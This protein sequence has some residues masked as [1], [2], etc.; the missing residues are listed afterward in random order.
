MRVGALFKAIPYPY[1]PQ[2]ERRIREQR[3][4][5]DERNRRDELAGLQAMASRALAGELGPTAK[6]VA[7][8]WRKHQ[9]V[10]NLATC[11]RDNL[12]QLRTLIRRAHSGAGRYR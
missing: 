6:S 11:G 12:E 2:Q 7:E 4:A 3:A 5:E 1:T 9:S 8:E 10:Q